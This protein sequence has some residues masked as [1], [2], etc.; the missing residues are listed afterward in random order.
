[1]SH[2]YTQE[3]TPLSLNISALAIGALSIAAL[4]A[5]LPILMKIPNPFTPIQ[6]A[7]AEPVTNVLPEILVELPEAP[8]EIKEL[9]K[10]TLDAPLPKVTIDQF[11]DMLTPGYHGKGYTVDMAQTFTE[12]VGRAMETFL[13]GQL[14]Q[15][16]RVLVA[17]TPLYPY[18][19]QNS[20]TS[21]EVM[22]EFVIKQDGRVERPRV[23]RASH[24]EFEQAAIDAVLKS[25]WQPGQ[26]NGK[27]VRT[28]VRLP[29]RFQ[30]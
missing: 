1:M 26:I 9:E 11:L 17:A 12:D 13:I 28:L 27:D 23:V 4:F 15:K 5:L 24:R 29:V 3:R 2:V 10:P 14:D 22:V 25:K 30:P 7:P 19:M 21:G 18:S 8:Q 6:L 20:K 16:P